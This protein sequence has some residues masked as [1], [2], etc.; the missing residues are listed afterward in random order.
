MRR[1]DN[2][3]KS[4]QTIDPPTAPHPWGSG[5]TGATFGA[6]SCAAG[7]R[8]NKTVHHPADK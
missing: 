2:A 7:R 5:W 3:S 6:D 4:G 1:Q 8:Q